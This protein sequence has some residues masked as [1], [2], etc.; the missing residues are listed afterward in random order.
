VNPPPYPREPSRVSPLRAAPGVFIGGAGSEWPALGREYLTRIEPKLVVS[1]EVQALARRLTAGKTG[2]QAKIDRL[3]QHVQTEYVYKPI[4]FGR[5]ARTPKAAAETL[6]HKYGDCKD[7]SVLL[8]GLLRAVGVESHLAL[9]HTREA[10]QK[11]LPSLD[12]FNHM[13]VWVPGAEGAPGRFYDPTDKWLSVRVSPPVA[14]ASAEALVLDP[15]QPRLERLPPYPQDSGPVQVTRAV[16]IDPD[17]GLAVTETLE[18]GGYYAASLRG[19]LSTLDTRRQRQW[20]QG[21]VAEVGRGAQLDSFEARDVREAERPLVV[22]LA[23]RLPER[24]SAEGASLRCALPSSW[25][26]YYL[27]VTPVPE[28]HTPFTV[29][30]PL[31]FVSRTTVQGPGCADPELEARAPGAESGFLKWTSAPTKERGVATLALE[32][33]LV[34]GTFPAARYGDYFR[35]SEQVIRSVGR[36]VTCG[37]RARAAQR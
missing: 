30:Y 35:E 8:H 14:L 2:R 32:A 20:A 9:I 36:S 22:K 5:R 6:G 15:A 23:Y 10:L 4:E 17:R 34:T 13:I 12:Q 25:E 28:R 1:P 18:L 31:H 3:V 29:E 16:R 24:C 27:G 33:T 19:H 37:D 11:D 7:L 21:V 26:G